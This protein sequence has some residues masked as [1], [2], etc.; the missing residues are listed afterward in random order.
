MLAYRILNRHVQSKVVNSSVYK[1][2]NQ[3]YCSNS[4]S[5]TEKDKKKRAKKDSKAK[6]DEA[7]QKLNVLLKKMIDDDIPAPSKQ[8]LNLARPKSRNEKIEAGTVSSTSEPIEKQIITAAKDVAESFGGDV[9]QTESELLSKLLSPTAKKNEEES[10]SQSLNLSDII[11]GMKIDRT[12]NPAVNNEASRAHQVR[13]LLDRAAGKTSRTDQ[14]KHSASRPMVRRPPV[15]S[16]SD[17]KREN[18]FGGQSLGIFTA[19]SSEQSEVNTEEQIVLKTWNALHERELRMAVTHPPENY[20]Q[21]M[22]LWTRQGKVW[23]FPIDNE[24]GM[25]QEQ[26]VYFAEHIFLDKHLE[27]WCPQKGPIRHFMELV[28]VGLSKN[29]Y[30]TVQAKQDHINWFKDY[31]MSKKQLLEEI[32][33]M[34]AATQNKI[35]AN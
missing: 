26:S 16:K 19:K 29:P 22:I 23:R 9:K 15:I 30:L 6:S 33:A 27:P 20:F 18:L 35:E 31:F 10:K 28:C 12:V 5:D 4:D 13:Q 21:E 11:S 2:L 3:T 24:Q 34:P 8:K 32:G 14:H 7:L 1:C 17:I 25:E